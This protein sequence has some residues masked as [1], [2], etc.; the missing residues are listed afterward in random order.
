MPTIVAVQILRALAA[1]AVVVS[2]FQFDLSRTIG[3][4]APYPVLQSGNAGVDLFFVLSGFVMVYASEPLFARPGGALTFW[5]HRLIRIVPL[6]W[7]ITAI[8]LLVAALAPRFERSDSIVTA[9]T[10]LLFI[11]YPRADGFVQPVIGQGWTLNYEMFFYAIFGLAVLWPRRIAVTIVSLT[12][13]G[14]VAS[15]VALAPRSVAL[16]FWTDPI[17]IEFVFGMLIAAAYRQGL[18][19]PAAACIAL[20]FAAAASF[21]ILTGLLSGLPAWRVLMWGVPAALTVAGASLGDF[22][23]A[24][25]PWRT[26][27]LVGDASYALYLIHSFPVRAVTYFARWAEL[28]IAR[29]YW[30]LLAVATAGAVA[31]AVALYYLFERPVTRGLRALVARPKHSAE[32]PVPVATRRT[33]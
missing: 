4:V 19:L 1:L 3:S 21:V 9:V 24:G 11:P 22:A 25:A 32:A 13:A 18:R 2:H 6:Y 28:D 17:I 14:M 27:A 8:Y 23:L 7:L 20:L 12:L 16:A 10:S 26:L 29:A 5:S 30:L 31:I 15:G 33:P